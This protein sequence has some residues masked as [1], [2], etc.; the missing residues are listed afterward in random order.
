MFMTR[1]IRSRRIRLRSYLDRSRIEDN[2]INTD[3]DICPN[4]HN[5]GQP[6]TTP[7]VCNSQPLHHETRTILVV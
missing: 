7:E 1:H 2:L 6:I 4:F 3:S 5:C